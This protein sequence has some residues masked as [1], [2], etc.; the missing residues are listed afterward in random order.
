MTDGLDLAH[1]PL[2]IDELPFGW[3]VTT[4]GAFAP[5]PHT[6]FAC[7]RHNSSG[8]G[9]P[10]LR[11]MNVSPEGVID[12]DDIRSVPADYDSRR[13]SVGDVLFNNTN[14]PA[15]VGK[16]AAVDR[17]LDL[18]FSNHMTVIRPPEGVSAPYL[19]RQLHYLQ[20]CG[21]FRHKCKNHVNQA[22]INRNV[23]A[24]TVP[25]LLPPAAEQ[26]RIADRIEE[27]FADLDAGVAALR[28]VQK[29]LKRYRSAL[30]HA[31]VTGRLT[32][33]W[34]AKHCDK[35]GSGSQLLERILVARR[36]YWEDKTLRNYQFDE[37]S[38]PPKWKERYPKPEQP[39]HTTLREL[40]E[41]W[42]LASHDQIGEVQ[43]GR[44]RSP[45]HHNGDHM[46]PYLRVANVF[47]DAIRTH[48]VLEMNF[49]PKEFATYELKQGDLLLNEGQS[50]ELVGRPAMFRNDVEGCCFQNTLV[51]QRVFEG[52]EPLY[53]L[54]VVRAQFRG[55]TYRQIA[56]ITTSIA[57][58]GADRFKR[59]EFPLPPLAEQHKIV[60]LVDERLSQIDA[61][62]SEVDRGLRRAD[63]LRQAI[64]KSAF[65]GKLVPRDPED[66]PASELL[67]R[68]RLEAEEEIAAAP[69]RTPRKRKAAKKKATKKVSP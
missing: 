40:P 21:Y 6:G 53:A 13:L 46:R 54:V 8:D 19:A 63:R 7:G 41:T 4:I 22:S 14:S 49:T 33:D 29:K 64:L 36:T 26:E 39:S 35:G 3:A 30:L 34:R 59:V 43:L 27:L 55:G 58:L 61:M 68:I 11:P 15:W 69:K 51:R 65:E 31:A 1:Y 47:E 42:T 62:E 45:Q 38:P 2:K 16:T 18:A 28:R 57:H 44:Q 20:R 37:R 17:K 60:E 9:V 23:L 32:A 24:D 5:S 56:K 67:A 12:L 50:M 25:I 10:H 52:V 48:D 66:K